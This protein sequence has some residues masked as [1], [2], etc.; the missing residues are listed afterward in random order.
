M[1][2]DLAHQ[3]ESLRTLRQ[4]LG[5]KQYWIAIQK[6]RN[7]FGA[8]AVN[9]LLGALMHLSRKRHRYWIMDGTTPA[10]SSTI[11][12]GNSSDDQTL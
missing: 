7:Q 3:L 1:T 6:L 4:L 12:L 11:A 9:V 10:R 5:E 2:S 8:N